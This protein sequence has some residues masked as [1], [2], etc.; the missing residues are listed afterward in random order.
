MKIK[1]SIPSGRDELGY[2][3]SYLCFLCRGG[4]EWVRFNLK[5]WDKIDGTVLFPIYCLLLQ[6]DG[7]RQ[8]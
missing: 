1:V 3:L 8:L 6:V 5:A 2:V 4:L 7:C